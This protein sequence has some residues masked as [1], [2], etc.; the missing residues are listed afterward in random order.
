M[1]SSIHHLA[2]LVPGF[3]T[4]GVPRVMTMLAQG[5]AS[6]VERIDFLVARLDTRPQPEFPSAVRIVDLADHRS[7]SARPKVA[8][9]RAILTSVPALA[10]YMRQSRPQLLLSGGNYAN[11][12]AVAGAALAR[13]ATTVVVSHHSDFDRELEKKPFARWITRNVYPRAAAIVAV[14][15]GVAR[16]LARGAH[17]KPEAITTIYNPAVPPELGH[18]ATQLIEHPW[19]APGQP[20]VI[21]GVGRLHRQKDFPTLIRAFARMRKQREARL[22]ILGT[23]RKADARAELR[24]LA[25]SVGIANDIDL[26]GHVENPFA[27][28]SRAAV[29]ILSSAWEGFGNVIVEALACGCPVVSTDCP[30]GPAEILADGKYGRLV[31]VGDDAALADAALQVLDEPRDRALLQ[32]RAQEFSADKATR[33]YLELINGLISD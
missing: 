5:L 6:D 2:I 1:P 11:F 16:S 32:T 19:L 17:L 26:P 25:E 15:Q 33:K 13:V 31:S 20:P 9:T 27:Y 10:A 21:L 30:S 14:S 7:L 3:N 18:L 29:F 22:I 28:M 12:T 24:A 23:G 4:G 8:N